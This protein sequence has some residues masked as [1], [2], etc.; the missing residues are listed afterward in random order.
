MSYKDRPLPTVSLGCLPAAVFGAIVGLISAFGVMMGH[1]APDAAGRLQC[2]GRGPMLM[3][4]VLLTISFCLMITW[5][6]NQIAARLTARDRPLWL[7]L[8]VGSAL[9]AAMTVPYALLLIAI[10]PLLPTQS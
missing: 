9:A 3:V 7:A 1:C 8:V 10:G 6:T 5:T 2:P 4:I